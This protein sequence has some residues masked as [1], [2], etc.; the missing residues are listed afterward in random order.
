MPASAHSWFY[1]FGSGT[2]LCFAI[3]VVT[4]ICLAFVYA[5]MAQDAWTSLLF[6]NYQ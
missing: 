2:L 1:V 3:Q 4:G 5:P 6:L